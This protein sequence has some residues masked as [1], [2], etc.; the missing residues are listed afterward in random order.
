ME[1]V[2]KICKKCGRY[3]GSCSPDAKIHKDC[4]GELIDTGISHDELMI[5]R[6]ISSDNAFLDAMIELKKTDIIEYNLKMSQFR[7]QVN[8]QIQQQ[9][10]NKPKCPTCGSTNL[11]KISGLSKAGSVAMWG[12][13]AAGRT[14]KTWHCNKCGTEW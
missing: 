7:A 1:T 9:E 5:I 3:G 2:L 12:V 10:T 6:K 13:F 8:Q 14:S 11:K 4:G